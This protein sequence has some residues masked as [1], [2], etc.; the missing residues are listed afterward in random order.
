[1]AEDK[2]VEEDI[3]KKEKPLPFWQR[4]HPI[5]LVGAMLLIFF[6]LKSIN[7]NE[8]EGTTYIFLI[9][10]VGV[11]VFLMGGKEETKA[12]IL[13]PFQAEYL[14]IKDIERKQAWGQFDIMSTFEYS[15]ANNMLYKDSKGKYYNIGVTEKNPY[16][17][18]KY[19]L[20]KIIAKGDFMGFVT[21]IKTTSEFTGRDIQDQKDMVAFPEFLRQAEDHPILKELWS[22]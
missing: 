1:M 22:K 11:I 21:Y 3:E 6:A 19:Y 10:V 20:A 17:R 8:G 4:V 5:I 18:D 2:E 9:I 7:L 16:E 12:R 13:K 15:V 14:V